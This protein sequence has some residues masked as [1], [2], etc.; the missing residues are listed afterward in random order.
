VRDG[1]ICTF[2]GGQQRIATEYCGRLNPL[3]MDEYPHH[4][5]WQGWQRASRMSADAIIER[6]IE[7]GLRGRGGGGFP[8]GRKWQL[9]RQAPG[10]P[11]YIVCNGDEG[12]PG[13]FMDRMIQIGRAHV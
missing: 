6:V 10:N 4:Q 11:K 1:E 2:L 13:A 3:D 9:T 8:T 5:G 12:D 7:S